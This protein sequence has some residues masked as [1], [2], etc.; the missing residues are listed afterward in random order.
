MLRNPEK[1]GMIA[2]FFQ[3]T[4]AFY[5]SRPPKKAGD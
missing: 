2:E 4:G 1:M 3:I 5:V